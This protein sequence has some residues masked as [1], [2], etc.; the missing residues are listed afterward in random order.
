MHREMMR[1]DDD[2][3]MVD[4]ASEDDID[5]NEDSQ[6]IDGV[7]A[8]HRYISASDVGISELLGNGYFNYGTQKQTY[9]LFQHDCDVNKQN[10]VINRGNRVHIRP[11]LSSAYRAFLDSLEGDDDE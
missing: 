9:K 11:N 3:F 6:F 7:N 2:D 1:D 4:V 8:E 5:E 10:H